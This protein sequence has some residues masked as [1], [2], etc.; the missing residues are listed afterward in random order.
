MTAPVASARQDPAGIKLKDGHGT[1]LAFAADPDISFWEVEVKPPGMDG[2]EAI[3]QTTHHNTVYRTKAPQSLIDLTDGE[4]T[5]QYDPVVV[6]QVRALINVETTLTIIYP[7]GSTDA[8][9]GYMK[10]FEPDPIVTGEPP[11][12]SFS[13]VATN[14]EPGTSDEEGPTYTDVAGT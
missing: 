10:S 9:Y 5:C 11:T 3:E 8:I 1:K 7:D 2:G 12:A 4:G 6:S 13:F 14:V